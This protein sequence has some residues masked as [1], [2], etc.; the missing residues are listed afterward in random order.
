MSL[1]KLSIK[2]LYNTPAV[3]FN[4]GNG[5]FFLTGKSI[6]ENAIKF[7]E[8][9]ADWL[10]KYVKSAKD[11]TNLHLNLEYFNTASAIW[12]SKIIKILS[13]IGSMDKLLIIHIYFHVEEFNEMEDE[14]IKE[15]IAPATDVLA[16]ATVSIGVKIY[17]IDNAGQVIKEKLILF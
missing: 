11:E 14:D 7:Y 15:A 10:S 13:G 17:G 9:I 4:P 16:E 12:I 3:D 2:A 8:P 6:P 5:N 1:K